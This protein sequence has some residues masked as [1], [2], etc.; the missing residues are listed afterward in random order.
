[1]LLL[2]PNS[3]IQGEQFLERPQNYLRARAG[4]F[5]GSP[6][7]VMDARLRDSKT[8]ANGPRKYFRADE[9]P[10]AGQS[11]SVENL[12]PEQLERAVDVPD[13]HAKQDA[14]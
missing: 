8:R 9:G 14:N 10:A 13:V 12:S 2:F 5:A 1:M 6:R 3:I 11:D 4:L 7:I